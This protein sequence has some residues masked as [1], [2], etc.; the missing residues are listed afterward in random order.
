MLGVDAQFDPLVEQRIAKIRKLR[1]A[2]INPYPYRYDRTHLASDVLAG[3]D[4]LEG[5]DVRVAGR[6]LTARV[7]GKASFAHML[8][9]SG[10][11]QIYVRRDKVGEQQYLSLI[12]ISEPT[13]LGITSYAV[14][15]LQKENPD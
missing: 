5:T 7:M 8:D 12:H 10:R 2:G 15:C 4:T 3:F 6:L 14:F 9:Q 13:R 1:E 11:I